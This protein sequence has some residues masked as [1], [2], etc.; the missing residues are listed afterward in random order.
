MVFVVRSPDIKRTRVPIKSTAAVAV[1]EGVTQA[2]SDALQ[3][4]KDARG[5]YQQQ[6]LLPPHPSINHCFNAASRHTT[7][8]CYCA[9]YCRKVHYAV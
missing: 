4:M 9:M 5:C 6:W 2:G 8:S 1:Q 7:C 3:S